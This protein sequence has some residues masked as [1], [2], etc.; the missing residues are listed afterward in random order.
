[1]GSPVTLSA[2]VSLAT[3]ATT[4]DDV[5]RELSE[6]LAA[7]GRVTD[8]DAFVTD[9]MNR[10]NV[11]STGIRGGIGIPH[12]RSE[13]VTTPSVAI[14]TSEKGIPFGAP[15]GPAHL[16]FLIAGPMN[17]DDSH[18]QILAAISRRT[19]NEE[20]RAALRSEENRDIVADI[21]NSEVTQ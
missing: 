8:V 7:E 5:I 3:P 20:F 19:M 10:E 17:A 18:L 9:V 13:H 2:L 15:D 4:K 14:A 1:M 6:L 21:L 12:A 16:V 11:M